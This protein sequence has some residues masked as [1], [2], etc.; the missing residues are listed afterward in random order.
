MSKAENKPVSDL[1]RD[2]ARRYVAVERFK[3]LRKR[4]LPYAESQ[5]ILTDEDA[6]LAAK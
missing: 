2:A 1:V 3:L 6:F 5:G 4:T